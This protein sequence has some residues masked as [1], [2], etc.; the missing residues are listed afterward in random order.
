MDIENYFESS[1]GLLGVCEI[2]Q[3]NSVSL[4]EAIDGLSV[5]KPF[6]F[7]DLAMTSRESEFL[8]K[9]S[10]EKEL[11]F[12]AILTPGSVKG[13]KL[14]DD[15]EN[16]LCK[17]SGQNKDISR[18]AASIIT[19]EFT[20]ILGQYSVAKLELTAQLSPEESLSWHADWSSKEIIMQY[21]NS[22]KI[23]SSVN[24]GSK[25]NCREEDVLAMNDK[26]GRISISFKGD[27]TIFSNVPPCY[28]EDMG[29]I[30]MGELLPPISSGLNQGAVF[31]A[32]A[33]YGTIHAQPEFSTPR[34]WASL[35]IFDN[36]NQVELSSQFIGLGSAIYARRG[37]RDSDLDI[38]FN[39]L[40]NTFNY[41]TTP[42]N[43]A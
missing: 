36:E 26:E 12:E 40:C 18:E 16:F 37:E 8:E 35:T 41:C 42:A 21:V 19:K 15:I 31:F 33:K 10:V 38:D 11:D 3:V 14:S 34:L 13:Q 7:F 43:L 30:G 6:G 28:R 23:E 4:R 22:C 27:K 32:N 5:E 24:Y 9:I 2:D 29:Q 25:L 17:V 20:N 39:Q 1:P